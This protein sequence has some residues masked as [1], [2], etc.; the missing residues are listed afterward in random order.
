MLAYK[1]EET[2]AGVPCGIQDQLAA[3]YGGVNV[4][5]LKANPQ[6][7][8]FQKKVVIKKSDHHKFARHLLLA[9]C[10]IPH[11]SRDINGRWVQ[12][13]LDGKNRSRW[14]EIL[15]CTRIFVDAIAKGDIE[16]A[17]SAV[18]RETRIRKEL[19]PDV[20]D[21]LGEKLVN[22]AESHGCGARFTGAGGGGCI[23]ALGRPEDIDRLKPI[24]EEVLSQRKKARL[25]D[26]SIDSS[27]AV[28]H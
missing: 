23:W 21:R 16:L 2:V 12:Q 26:F 4:W 24:W 6:K 28:V 15:D 13:F 22:A 8:A 9:Y 25:F 17:V 11:E 1:I 18:I 20:V 7:S 5:Y 14:P 27:G 10:G 19:T 3:A